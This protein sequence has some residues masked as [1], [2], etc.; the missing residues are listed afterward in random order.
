VRHL[1]K[2]GKAQRGRKRVGANRSNSKQN[3]LAQ[4]KSTSRS[5][6][7]RVSHRAGR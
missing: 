5:H 4:T 6:T 1:A 3:P 2:S 7:K